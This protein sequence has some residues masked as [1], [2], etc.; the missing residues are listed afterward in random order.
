MRKIEFN[1][2]LIFSLLI[3]LF[4]ANVMW[5]STESLSG[6]CFIQDKIIV[7]LKD[8]ET[9]KGIFLDSTKESIYF[10]Q[11][12]VGLFYNP[13]PNWVLF[14]DIE[15]ITLVD[16]TVLF[17][18]AVNFLQ[19]ECNKIDP[20]Q[21]QT[22]RASEKSFHTKVGVPMSFFSMPGAQL[23]PAIHL[24]TSLEVLKSPSRS[25]IWEL[26]LRAKRTR[27]E[28]VRLS[29]YWIGEPPETATL[30]DID[31]GYLFLS[32][33]WFYNI[34]PFSNKSVGLYVGPSL[35]LSV[36]EFSKIKDT[37]IEVPYD[38]EYDFQRIEDP[39]PRGFQIIENSGFGLHAGLFYKLNSSRIEVRYSLKKIRKAS[40]ESSYGGYKDLLYNVR[41]NQRI[42]ASGYRFLC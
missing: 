4:S 31:F 6:E 32:G 42:M 17:G 28:R 3:I 24:G 26:S 22:E 41:R 20:L 8:G 18:N 36:A 9:L 13:K 1:F 29:Q 39:A 11:N 37:G 12:R 19:A 40:P 10:D 34:Y 2:I 7:T 25:S 27:V 21:T 15:R 38:E 14:D 33:S 23:K 16:S 30:Y 35:D 5:A